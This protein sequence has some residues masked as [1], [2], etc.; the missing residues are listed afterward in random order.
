LEFLFLEDYTLAWYLRLAGWSVCDNQRSSN[1]KSGAR[2]S[3]PTYHI[4]RLLRTS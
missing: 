3:L 2:Y 1:E 4:D